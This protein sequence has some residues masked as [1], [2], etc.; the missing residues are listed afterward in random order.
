MRWY[1]SIAV[2]ALLWGCSPKPNGKSMLSKD[3]SELR[4][5]FS[6]SSVPP[7]YHRSY[8]IWVNAR[9]AR[10][11]VSDYDTVLA[12]S[13]VSISPE[14][15]TSL[16]EQA[17]K[18]SGNKRKYAEGAAGQKGHLVEV[19][20]DAEKLASYGWDSLTE[21]KADADARSLRQQIK[22]CIPKLAEIIAETEK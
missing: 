16:Q 2:L 5:D 7:P 3:I 17:G 15:W 18:I 4:Y 21:D 20:S 14:Q 1:I 9:E 22:A 12:Q 6:D 19:I 8:T 11:E 10:V 13:T